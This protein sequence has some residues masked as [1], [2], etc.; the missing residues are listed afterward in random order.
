MFVK[1]FKALS[2]ILVIAIFTVVINK[3]T[4]TPQKIQPL[5]LKKNSQI[6]SP[7][8]DISQTKTE[9]P[10]EQEKEPTPE[11]KE[12][13]PQVTKTKP[14][15]PVAATEYETLTTGTSDTDESYTPAQSPCATTLG[16][17]IG[18]FDSRF[19]I[20]QDAFIKTIEDAADMWGQVTGTKLFAY[21]EHGTLTIN[22]IYDKRQE[23]TD[24]LN[25]L[26]LDIENAKTNAENLRIAYQKDKEV[27]EREGKQFTEDAENFNTR[28][29]AYSEKVAAYNKE[30]GAPQAEYTSM[31]A[32][33]EK[34]KQEAAALD[35]RQSDLNK[36]MESIN[37]RV[38]KY[39]E[40]VAYINTL[41]KKSNA[42]GAQKFTEG[43][44]SPRT[45]T[46]DIYQYSNL[47]KLKR[48]V[49]HELGHALGVNH[50]KTVHSIMY[51]VNIATSTSLST[52]DKE[53][54]HTLCSP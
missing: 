44:F 16:F 26:A 41:I 24:T 32:E 48:V 31:M 19:G 52:D 39:N 5:L 10:Q 23:D 29:K 36:Q 43:R 20:T 9:I 50:T 7:V 47:A 34:L 18:T 21:N 3:R 14:L 4:L 11:T 45:N 33:V 17:K 53:A 15:E 28:Y 27:Y 25:Y 12:L 22:L 38:A 46:I 13:N 2:L 49:A 30:G 42:L 35:I 6:A 37:V 8:Q 54:L 51:S 40:F 1:V